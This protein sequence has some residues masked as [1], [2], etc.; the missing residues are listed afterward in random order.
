MPLSVAKDQKPH[1]FRRSENN[2]PIFSKHKAVDVGKCLWYYFFR[3]REQSGTFDLLI[4]SDPH[5]KLSDVTGERAEVK[6]QKS[7][8]GALY[9]Y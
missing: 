2:F 5:R 3:P 1:V 4:P 8:E 9:F 7:P 6:R